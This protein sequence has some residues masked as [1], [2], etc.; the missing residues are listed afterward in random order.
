MIFKKGD[1]VR[2][3]KNSPYYSW[4]LHKNIFYYFGVV[5]GK[6]DNTREYLLVD[7]YMGN[8]HIRRLFPK[9]EIELIEKQNHPN[10]NIFK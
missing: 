2:L 10:T 9:D 6:L 8:H 4:H 3:K 5:N 1:R 7:D